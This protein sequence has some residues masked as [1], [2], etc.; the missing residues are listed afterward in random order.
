MSNPSPDLLFP[1]APWT[2][3]GTG[4]QLAFLTPVKALAEIV[5]RHLRLRS[6]LPGMTL[7]VL[8]FGRYTRGST[9]EYGELI[10]SPAL[11]TD[12]K[13]SGLWISQIYVDDPRS[14]RGGQEIWNL[15]KRLAE[16]EWSESSRAVSVRAEGQQLCRVS[17]RFSVPG[18]IPAWNIGA[19]SVWRGET[20]Y[21]EGHAR[22]RTRFGSFQ[23]SV[24][25]AS[26]LLPLLAGGTKLGCRHTHAVMY[27]PPPLTR[28]RIAE[29]SDG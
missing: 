16:F 9:L 21:F 13:H 12:G 17:E 1:P 28:E 10:V 26:P 20:T 22:A 7:G 5:P 18:W 25:E 24:P 19:F 6:V 23:V 4:I 27:V 11:V 14:V 29:G 15:D 3:Q 2:L 8:S